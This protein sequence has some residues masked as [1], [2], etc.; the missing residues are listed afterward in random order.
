MTTTRS[1]AEVLKVSLVTGGGDWHYAIPMAAGLA[2]HTVHVDVLA[3]A[4]FMHAP[5]M[6]HSNITCLN[7]Y[8]E[9]DPQD[10]FYK[11]VHRVVS[12]YFQLIAYA[13]RTDATLFHIL[14]HNKFPLFDRTVLTIYY[15]ALGKKLIF[16]A[17]NVDTAERDGTSGPVTRASLRFMYRA[18]D[19]I[20][21]HTSK[22]KQ[23]LQQQFALD[24]AK[25]SV[26]PF[27]MNT[28]VPKSDIT[29]AQARRRLGIGASE[30]VALFFGNLAPYKGLEHLVRALAI[31][32]RECSIPLKL[33]IAGNVK[34]RRSRPY[35]NEIRELIRQHDLHGWIR[36]E[37]RFIPDQDIELFFKSADVCV[38]PY[39]MIY[40]TGVLFLSYRFGTPVV[41][42]DVGSMREDIL[43][44]QTGFVCGPADPAALAQ[45][46]ERYF[47][48]D[49]YA[50]LDRARAEISAHA[51]SKYS[52]LGIASTISDVYRRL[53]ACGS[54]RPLTSAVL[55]SATTEH[56]RE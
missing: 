15:K 18:T 38:L 22:M 12:A 50:G 55:K 35:W 25:I 9:A 36:A 34:N 26:I 2:G 20:F 1:R 44:G 5:E 4:P 10:G 24:G 40:Q 43:E 41:A 17:H 39:A 8:G 16:T 56:D 21:V 14:W 51:E 42:T 7:V 31:L 30:R 52:W 45:T 49:L 53:D 37:A 32:K 28:V 13:A 47:D 19:H 23:Q 33:L 11:K 27:G 46:L 3:S 29:Q 6:R 48:S 54:V